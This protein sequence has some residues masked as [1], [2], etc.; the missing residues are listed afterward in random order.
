MADLPTAGQLI[1]PATTEKQFKEALKILVE[2]VCSLDFINSNRLFKP[3]LLN[4]N[5]NLNDYIENGFFITTTSTIADLARNFPI[6][7]GGVLLVNKVT[8][9]YIYQIYFGIDTYHVRRRVNG[10]W[11]ALWKRF[12]TTDEIF[13]QLQPIALTNVSNLNDYKKA[14][15]FVAATAD[16]AA[17]ERNFPL[18]V[19]G[20]LTVYERS[21]SV[22]QQQ[23]ATT[24]GILSRVSSGTTTWTEWR[25]EVRRALT[26]SD[27]LNNL[28][29]AGTYHT[30]SGSIATALLNYPFPGNGGTVSVE[31]EG[32][33][34]RQIVESIA[35]T[36]QR[37]ASLADNLWTWQ[38]WR[39]IQFSSSGIKKIDDM[40]VIGQVNQ[41]IV[42]NIATIGHLDTA[43]IEGIYHINNSTVASTANGFPITGSGGFLTIKKNASSAIV[44]Q[45]TTWNGSAW[46]W[47]SL[48]GST[49]TW[50]PWRGFTN[51][52][53]AV[54]DIAAVQVPK[55]KLIVFGSSTMW[56][57]SDE[58]TDLAT[59]KNLDFINHGV[60]GDTTF[61]AGQAQ[62]SNIV[63]LQFTGGVISSGSSTPV[64]ESSFGGVARHNRNVEL[65][66]AVKGV[67]R[68]DGTFV[69]SN[70]SANLSVSATEK[71]RL[72]E[73]T[74]F[75]VGD[76]IYVINIGKNDVSTTV[77]NSE[78]IFNRTVSI[79]DYLPKGTRFVIG[80][81]YSNTDSNDMHR[82]V[83]ESVSDKLRLKYGLRYF[84][85]SELLFSDATWT[86]LGLTK[87]ADDITA[88]TNRRLPPS[89]SRDV[90]HLSQA[91]DI[92]LAR[93]IE[94]K[95]ISLGYIS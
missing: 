77:D 25:G 75:N 22:I 37:F 29:D 69:A 50:Q 31:K 23:Y 17:I 16:V 20:V 82:Q 80:G 73:Y 13:R 47:G 76:G 84:D 85:I 92:I 38:P 52:T 93:T 21:A 18:A 81:H 40:L 56:Y 94:N 90:A 54:I 34:V 71:F 48:S 79:V 5:S 68:T 87:T 6:K 70:L 36:A 11:D 91:M 15:V 14:G 26:S 66:N 42:T 7:T 59:R 32:N 2:N 74:W 67:L 24:F 4:L 55:T 1:N 39:G 63:T 83:V 88:I 64:I 44:Q 10:V 33:L 41:D 46:R 27:N 58:F 12:D 43:L 65:S 60:S 61:G 49:V 62:G 8:D 9:A 30:P 95:L 72:F 45:W 51:A 57:L 53:N 3:E 86:E 28:F 78:D 35:G 19:G 89:L